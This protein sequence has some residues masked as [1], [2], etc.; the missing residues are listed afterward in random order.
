MLCAVVA[1]LDHWQTLIG[2]LA[3]GLMGVV[4]ALIVAT[5]GTR[6]ERRIA[7]SVVL[8]EVISLQAAALNIDKWVGHLDQSGRERLTCE[9]LMRQ[10]PQI[11]ALHSPVVSQLYDVD[12]RLYSHLFQCQMIHE[13]LEAAL[14][15]FALAVNAATAPTESIE[16]DAQ[17][18]MINAHV[19]NVN[20][21]WSYC[22]EHATLANYYLDRFIFR[23]CAA[24]IFRLRMRLLPIDLDRRS[25]HLLQTGSVLTIVYG[26]AHRQRFRDRW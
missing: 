18:A 22:V 2:S 4:G 11:Q 14:K 26:P 19:T 17:A 25:A 7:A 12:A 16:G 6:R 15:A 20:M 23:R 8:P 10:P 1:F 5:R 24:W 21:T 3:G 13:R 9:M